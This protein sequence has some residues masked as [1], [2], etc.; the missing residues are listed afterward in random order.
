MGSV[1]A[2]D[3]SGV[4]WSPLLA[5][6]PPMTEREFKIWNAIYWI[7]MIWLLSVAALLSYDTYLMWFENTQLAILRPNLRLK[8][9]ILI[10]P[11]LSI[12]YIAIMKRKKYRGS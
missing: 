2:Y 6:A 9:A 12:Y 7:G 8:T 11:A 10:L 5:T 3:L 1:I 4:L